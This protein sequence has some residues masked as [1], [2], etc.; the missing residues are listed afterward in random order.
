G[1]AASL[2]GTFWLA[3]GPAFLFKLTYA[4]LGHEDAFFLS[5]IVFW[6]VARTRFVRPHHWL[7]LGL[8]TGA[9]VW[10]HR[11]ILFAIVPALMVIL[12]FDCRAL[13]RVEL[14]MAAAIFTA[15]AA[16]AYLP[17]V[18]G[19]YG[20]DQRLYGPVKAP[21]TPGHVASR[22]ADVVTHDFWRLIG[23]D[24][25]LGWVGGVV[26][27]ALL[28]SAIRRFEPRRESWLAAGIVAVSFAVFILSNDVQRGAVRYIILTIPIFY[29]FAAREIV[30]LWE[31]QRV[32]GVAVAAL[33]VVSLFV[34]RWQQTTAVVEARLEVHENWGGFDPRPALRAVAEGRYTVCY[35][36]VWVAHKLEWLSDTGVRFIPYRSVNRRMVESLRLGALPGPKCFV[37]RNGGV[38]A[39]TREQETALR[40][41]TLWLMHGW[42]RGGRP[43]PWPAMP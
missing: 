32:A 15:A 3:A 26:I 29:A 31:W 19:R 12:F 20:F 16:V 36:N 41:D 8:L 27:F 2:L 21:W 5:A 28:V 42:R 22:I 10:I 7:I 39:L 34:P 35:A 14:A 4:P 33:I 13:R 24:T 18:I 43:V 40:L 38:H 30:R 17:A 11:G 6:Y 1:R 23:A 25:P 9:G 37:D